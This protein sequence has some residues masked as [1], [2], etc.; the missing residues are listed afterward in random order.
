LVAVSIRYEFSQHFRVPAP[1]AFAWC[2]DYT[3]DDHELMGLK[4]RRRF[5]RLTEETLLLD[6]VI[7]SGAKGVRKTKIVK[8]DPKR[9]TYYN[10]HLTGP[11]RHSLYFYEMVPDGE[12]ESRLDYT[13]YEVFYPKKRPTK[14][15]LARMAEAE[16]T[17]WH[18]EWGSLARAMEK[19]LRVRG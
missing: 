11:N 10:F 19:D 13:G 1:D 18:K 5:T 2:T 8:L 3:P 14:E 16:S 12:G 7:Y 15:Q 17:G 6:D 4:G 9:L